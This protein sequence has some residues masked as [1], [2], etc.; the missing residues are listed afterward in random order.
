MKIGLF[1]T[2]W[3]LALV[4]IALSPLT[5]LAFNITMKV[6]DSPK[7]RERNRTVVLHYF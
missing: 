4:F 2:G 6:R 5:I 3:K 7:S 1:S